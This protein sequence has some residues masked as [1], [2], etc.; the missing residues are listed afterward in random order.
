[1]PAR[2]SARGR[3]GEQTSKR[4]LVLESYIAMKYEVIHLVDGAAMFIVGARLVKDEVF[5]PISFSAS[6]SCFRVVRTKV[7]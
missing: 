4:I 6:P 7:A 1:V 5:K 3:Y 2:T